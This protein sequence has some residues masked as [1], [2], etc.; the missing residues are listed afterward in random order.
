MGLSFK[1]LKLKSFLIINLLYCLSIHVDFS[2]D[3]RTTKNRICIYIVMAVQRNFILLRYNHILTADVFFTFKN[4]WEATHSKDMA[5][6]LSHHCEEVIAPLNYLRIGNK[7]LT[8]AT[9]KNK[10]A[11]L[12]P[13]TCKNFYHLPLKLQNSFVTSFS[14]SQVQTI[15]K[16][17]RIFNI[18]VTIAHLNVQRI[19]DL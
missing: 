18:G 7:V 2:R 15:P 17:F 12:I 5:P 1:K 3:W 6:I 16:R 11:C 9:C 14:Y 13:T 10:L 8:V 19:F 4:Y